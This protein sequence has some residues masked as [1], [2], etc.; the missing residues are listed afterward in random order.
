MAVPPDS[1]LIA[2]SETRWSNASCKTVYNDK[3]DCRSPVRPKVGDREEL[4]TE[5]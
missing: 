3:F 5:P 4:S 1:A 2:R